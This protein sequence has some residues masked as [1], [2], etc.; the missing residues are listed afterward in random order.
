MVVHICRKPS[1][2]CIPLTH[3]NKHHISPFHGAHIMSVIAI[4]LR[5]QV[6]TLHFVVLNQIK[7]TINEKALPPFRQKPKHLKK[8]T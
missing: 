8:F 1:A 5:E 4:S 6:F 7:K 3:S 2:L